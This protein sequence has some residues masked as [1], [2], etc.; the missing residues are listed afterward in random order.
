ML[1]WL[2]SGRVPVLCAI[3]YKDRDW[4]WTSPCQCNASLWQ[5]GEGTS[6]LQLFFFPAFSG[7]E[8][9]LKSAQ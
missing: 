2:Q 1:Q 6:C 8:G 3:G 9:M 7:V 4:F 5:K